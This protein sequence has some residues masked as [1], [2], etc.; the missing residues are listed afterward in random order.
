MKVIVG[1]AD[2]RFEIWTR[3]GR[4][5]KSHEEIEVTWDPLITRV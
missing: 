1:P 2:I 4:I 3:D 5:S